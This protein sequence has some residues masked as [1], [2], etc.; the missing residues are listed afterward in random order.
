MSEPKYSYYITIMGENVGNAFADMESVEAEVR[1]IRNYL[2]KRHINI[3]LG[4]TKVNENSTKTYYNWDQTYGLRLENGELYSRCGFGKHWHE[5]EYVGKGIPS[6]C[7]AMRQNLL[8]GNDDVAFGIKGIC[9]SYSDWTGDPF[10]DYYIEI[11]K[12]T[13]EDVY[14]FFE[15]G[16]ARQCVIGCSECCGC[17]DW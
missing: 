3:S 1:T 14:E 17:G 9:H 13:Q 16:G 12:G 2:A 11:L 5:Y 7:Q 10:E 8:L 15:A 4:W 6:A